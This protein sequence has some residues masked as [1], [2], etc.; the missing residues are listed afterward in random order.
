M[1]Y[2]LL[3]KNYNI[4]KLIKDYEIAEKLH[5]FI[6]P[7]K[8]NGKSFSISNKT[9]G[10]EA[11][12]LNSIDGTIGNNATIPNYTNEIYNYVPNVILLK[13]KYISK[14]LNDLNTDIYLVRLMKLKSGGYI[15]PH[16]DEIITNKNIIRCQI[17]IKTNND[18]KFIIDN[19]EVNLESGNLYFINAGNKIHSVKNN[20]NSD[21][22]SIVIDLKPNEYINNLL[23]INLND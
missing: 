16:I 2:K 22:I 14:I 20:S 10:W 5:G 17:P 18:I 12:P 11:I 7:E 21:R 8:Y 9:F 19:E 23:K 15:Y 1:N 3:V 4:E 13:C 6:N